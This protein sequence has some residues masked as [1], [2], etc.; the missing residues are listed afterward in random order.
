MGR[1]WLRRAALSALPAPW[2]LC[3]CLDCNNCIYCY[4]TDDRLPVAAAL[5]KCLDR[6]GAQSALSAY[7]IFY[8]KVLPLTPQND[9]YFLC[10]IA[11][12][13]FS[14]FWLWSSVVSVLISV[15]TDMSPTGQLLTVTNSYSQLLTLVSSYL[16][17]LTVIN[18]YG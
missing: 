11:P 10:Q 12:H 9:S 3:I 14:A 7:I 18:T 6:W 2:C 16:N 15:T 1:H 8:G 13:T 17:I 4:C 5:L